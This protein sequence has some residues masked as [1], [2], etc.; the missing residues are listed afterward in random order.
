MSETFAV[1]GPAHFKDGYYTPRVTYEIGSDEIEESYHMRNL[2]NELR[3]SDKAQ[4]LPERMH[5]QTAGIGAHCKKGGEFFND[6]WTT[7][8]S[9]GDNIKWL[10]A[11]EVSELLMD[12]ASTITD[13]V[14]KAFLVFL[15]ML[16]AETPV[17]LYC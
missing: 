10:P 15:R 5:I 2:F 16:P 7:T 17:V 9:N 8:A 12:K 6:N 4:P 3:Q 1:F 14:F 13:Q 11:S